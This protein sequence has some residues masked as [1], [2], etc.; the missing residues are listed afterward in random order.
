M[1][2]DQADRLIGLME[3][4]AEAEERTADAAE[5]AV[6]ALE[7]L[8]CY[9]YGA[10]VTSGA[11]EVDASPALDELQTWPRPDGRRPRGAA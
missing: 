4:R 8:T 11:T 5:R 1:G 6:D 3:R 10:A 2:N 9:A 7:A